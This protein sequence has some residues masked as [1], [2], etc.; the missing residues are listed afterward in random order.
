M[1]L[2]QEILDTLPIAIAQDNFL[3]VSQHSGIHLN[4]L[5]L[6]YFVQ[7]ELAKKHNEAV[8]LIGGTEPQPNMFIPM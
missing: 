4:K 1:E 3:A 2:K 5:L 7:S 6:D 8:Q